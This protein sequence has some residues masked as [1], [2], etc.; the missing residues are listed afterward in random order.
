MPSPVLDRLLSEGLQNNQG[1]R[2][3]TS[4]TGSVNRIAAG[5]KK[6]IENGGL[7]MALWHRIF[8]AHRPNSMAGHN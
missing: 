4:S 3:Q 1:H 6:A 2:W 7:A 5:G 8:S